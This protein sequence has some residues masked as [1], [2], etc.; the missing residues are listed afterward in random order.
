[1]KWFSMDVPVGW[2]AAVARSVIVAVIAF[3]VLQLKEFV[4]AGSFDTPAT[5]TDALL[6]AAAL[7]AVNAI[8]MLMAPRRDQQQSMARR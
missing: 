7:L 5:G 2:G 4:D 3:V 6:I 1:M 8:F